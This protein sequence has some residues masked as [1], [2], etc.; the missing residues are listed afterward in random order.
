MMT[1]LMILVGV[2]TAMVLLGAAVSES[3]TTL[4]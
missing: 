1:F 3:V 2:F 4:G